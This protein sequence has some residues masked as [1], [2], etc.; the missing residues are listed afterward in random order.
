[1][2]PLE[3]NQRVLIW[4]C[5]F[6]TDSSAS[7]WEKIAHIAFTLIVIATNLLSVV[8]SSVFIYRNVSINL[9]E[10]LFSLF[11]T[12]ASASMLYQ[13]IAIVILCRELAAIFKTLAN[14][15]DASKCISSDSPIN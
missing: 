10:T 4:L 9:E 13:S 14:I 1:M 12:F 3:T 11:H 6:P 8:S 2:K 7:K 5:G 15:Y